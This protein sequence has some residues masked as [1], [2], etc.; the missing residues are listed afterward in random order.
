L[1]SLLK[2]FLAPC[3]LSIVAAITQRPFAC[4][5][6]NISYIALILMVV[7]SY[8]Y[9]IAIWVTKLT[10]TTTSQCIVLQQHVESKVWK[11]WN[12]VFEPRFSV[13]HREYHYQR[14]I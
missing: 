7:E 14:T 12:F 11:Y 1:R 13:C 4:L 5:L 2:P 6:Y 8:I 9:P 10:R 3:R